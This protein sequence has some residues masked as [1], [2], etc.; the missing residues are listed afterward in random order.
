[1]YGKNFWPIQFSM[2]KYMAAQSALAQHCTVRM[3]SRNPKITVSKKPLLLPP[4]LNWGNVS[5]FIPRR[6]TL[7][8]RPALIYRPCTQLRL[9]ALK[10][11]KIT[12]PCKK[13]QLFSLHAGRM[14]GLWACSKLP[15]GK[16]TTKKASIHDA[17]RIGIQRQTHLLFFASNSL[18][19]RLQ[20]FVRL[21]LYNLLKRKV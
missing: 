8:A 5:T 14:W 7:A 17:R 1:M 18:A 9:L 11:A 4:A 16:P 6:Q 3:K 13:F 21:K 2:W 12:V 19:R 15:W 20:F 10:R